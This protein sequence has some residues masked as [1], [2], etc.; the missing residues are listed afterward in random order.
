MRYLAGEQQLLLEALH[1]LGAGGKFGTDQF[2]RD[3][4]AEFGVVGFVDRTHA[5]F[6]EQGLDAVAGAESRARRHVGWHDGACAGS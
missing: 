5:A 1:G 2:E 3:G 6:T 4:A